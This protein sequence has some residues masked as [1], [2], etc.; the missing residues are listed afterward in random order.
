M[1]SVFQLFVR[2]TSLFFSI[3][4]Y[5][6]ISETDH[7][8]NNLLV[9]FI[10][11]HMNCLSLCFSRMF[12]F[13]S[14]IWLKISWILT[15]RLLQWHSI[16]FQSIVDLLTSWRLSS[17]R[18]HDVFAKF[19]CSQIPP[20][21]LLTS[22]SYFAE[23]LFYFKQFFFPQYFILKL[24]L[25]LNL[26]WNLF[27]NMIWRKGHLIKLFSKCLPGCRHCLWNTLLPFELMTFLDHV[28][29]SLIPWPASGLSLLFQWS[30]CLFLCQLYRVCSGF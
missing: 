3:S 10:F 15:L 7:S 12:L 17:H 27:L 18:N 30:V 9:I 8:L 6:I 28:V 5:L 2:D 13:S 22:D 14:F 24:L 25:L 11:S 1:M 19:P 29:S 21:F 16:L 20:P 26:S 23:D 4:N